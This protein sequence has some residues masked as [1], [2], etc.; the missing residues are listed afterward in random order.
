[1]TDGRHGAAKSISLHPHRVIWRVWMVS[2]LPSA[3]LCYALHM[4]TAYE[5]DAV[6]P[7]LQ[8]REWKFEEIKKCAQVVQW[9]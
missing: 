2:A 7:P 1:M 9:P 3:G 8:T 4:P 5:G 6:T